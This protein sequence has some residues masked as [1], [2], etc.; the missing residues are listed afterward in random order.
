[1]AKKDPDIKDQVIIALKKELLSKLPEDSYEIIDSKK[2]A[3]AVKPDTIVK[4][5]KQVFDYF[6]LS[7]M[8]KSMLSI[9][10]IDEL[11]HVYL[12]SVYEAT[13]AANCALLLFDEDDQSFKCAKAIGIDPKTTGQIEF[14]KEEGLFW[15]ILN[16]GEPFP[17]VDSFGNYRFEPVIKKWGLERLNSQIWVPLIVKN[18]LVGVLT[19][20]RK[21]DGGVYQETE[22][23]FVLQMG[24]QAAIAFESAILDEQKERASRELAKKMESL[25]ILYSVSKALN[26]ATDL[27][28]I[29]LFILDKARDAV[30]AKKA[31]LMLLDKQTNELVVHVVRGV[32]PDVEEKINTGLMDCT[33]IKVGEGIAGRVAAEKKHMLIN[34]AKEDKRFQK[35]DKSFVDSILCMPLIANEEVIGVVNLTNK[36]QGGNFTNEDVDMLSTLSNQAAI[37]IYNARLYHLAITDGMTQL[38][39]HRYFQQRL[40]EELLRSKE[41]NHPV[42]L[43]MSDIDH[44]KSFNDTY[45]HQQGDIVLIDTAKIFRTSVREVDIAARYGGEEFAV[46]LPETDTEGAREMAEKLRKA[47]EAHEYPSKQGKLK[48]TISLGVGTYPTHATAKEDL[49]KAADSA[50]Y[51]AKEAGRNRVEV[52]SKPNA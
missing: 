31:S 50:L 39:I 52:A 20:G 14:K 6:T 44:F 26:F 45:G 10:K 38:R 9:Q 37:T 23:S 21:K 46:I 3:S 49:I 40:D 36:K 22:L 16:S 47:I 15:Q 48:V 5:E 4:L 18:K 8:G 25:S 1:M 43:I 2:S 41:F 17:I 33:R 42:S 29:L 30:D 12:S 34:D 35:S 13:E 27:K 28:K 51:V 19:L 24:N 7:Q 32:P 11:S